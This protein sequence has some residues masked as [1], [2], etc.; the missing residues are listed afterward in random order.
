VIFNLTPR[1]V[2]VSSA[3]KAL[4]DNPAYKKAFEETKEFY[5]KS[6]IA[7]SPSQKEERELIYTAMK[8]LDM[9]SGHIQKRVSEGDAYY[10]SLNIE[11]ELKRGQK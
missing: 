2:E 4:M 3:A 9:V 1:E 5:Q 7:T 8:L 10:K 11:K 6:W